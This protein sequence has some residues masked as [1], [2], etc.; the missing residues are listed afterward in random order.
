MR[1]ETPAG[2]YGYD[3]RHCYASSWY[4]AYDSRL[5]ALQGGK[6]SYRDVPKQKTSQL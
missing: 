6:T 4:S 5:R 2:D 1:F 3:V